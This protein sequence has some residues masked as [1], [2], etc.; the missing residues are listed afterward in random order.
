M[1]REEQVTEVTE[2]EAGHGERGAG[3]CTAPAG[4]PARGSSTG[5]RPRG[6]VEAALLAAEP[7]PRRAGLGRPWAPPPL[8]KLRSDGGCAADVALLRV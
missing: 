5:T 2:S 3:P 1:E 6:R 4:R 8:G 7:Q